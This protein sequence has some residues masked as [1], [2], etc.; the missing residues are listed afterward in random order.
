VAAKKLTG[1]IGCRRNGST[2]DMIPTV[3]FNARAAT[4]LQSLSENPAAAGDRWPW[5]RQESYNQA[6]YNN[7]SRLRE[8]GSFIKIVGKLPAPVESTKA[9]NG[10]K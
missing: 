1:W 9:E 6:S 10:R 2:A 7:A 3:I 5:L 4:I 8:I